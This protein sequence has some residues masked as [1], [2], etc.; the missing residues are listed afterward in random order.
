MP[1]WE[2]LNE[3]K[4][5]VS[6]ADRVFRVQLTRGKRKTSVVIRRAKSSADFHVEWFIYRSILPHMSIRTARLWGVFQADNAEPGWMVLEDLR[7]AWVREDCRE[8]REAFL[9]VL[10]CLHG[11]GLALLQNNRLADSPI[12]QYPCV[13]SPYQE[14]R[15]V[16]AEN[17]IDPVYGLEE[18]MLSLPDALQ[19]RLSQQ[20]MTLLHGD[21]NYSN[22]LRVPFEVALIDWE[23][24][25]IGPMSLDLGMLME[26]VESSDELHSYHQALSQASRR[27]WSEDQIRLWADLGE[28]YNRLG[29]ICDYIQGPNQGDS[30]N[31]QWHKQQYEPRVERLRQ[32]RRR[33]ADWW[34]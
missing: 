10:G 27:E 2:F 11:E 8:D 23:S 3:P 21:A 14:W 25:Y 17:L 15:T 9:R 16:L 29:W 20:P 33:R 13:G 34:S 26:I 6:A 1:G 12:P 5:V 31:P 24:A 22:A 4:G 18:W 30:L 7:A 32:L 19:L 28:G